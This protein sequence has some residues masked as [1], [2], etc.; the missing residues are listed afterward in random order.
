MAIKKKKTKFPPKRKNISQKIPNGKIVRT[1]DD[2]LES[3][4]YYQ[5][6][7]YSNKGNYRMGIVVDSNKYDELAIVKGTTSS[8]GKKI[9][10]NTATKPYI[11][12]KDNEGKPIKAG[13]KF[14]P[15]KTKN[16]FSKHEVNLIK[17]QA[18]KEAPIKIKK[19]NQK[20]LHELK[21]RK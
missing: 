9:R 3:G 13:K 17:K 16:E 20:K 12:T 10:G 7:G 6:Q 15:N 19:Q 21:R 5:K 8:K 11:E 14:I 4:K 1:R 18:L 2:Y